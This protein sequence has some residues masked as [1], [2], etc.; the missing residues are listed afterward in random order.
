MYNK[1]PKAYQPYITKKYIRQLHH[2]WTTQTNEAL[3]KSVS[4]YAPKDRTFPT[5]Q[6]LRTRVDIAA[7]VQA[8]GQS[9]F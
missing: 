4:A 2:P 7:Y 8:A 3:N 6:S 1:I 5:T 9:V